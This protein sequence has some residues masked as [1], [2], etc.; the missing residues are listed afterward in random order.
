M[1][2]VT[3]ITFIYQTL[4]VLKGRD[5]LIKALGFKLQTLLQPGAATTIKLV[6]RKTTDILKNGSF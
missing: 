3:W 2:V 4:P 5:S 1:D 6:S